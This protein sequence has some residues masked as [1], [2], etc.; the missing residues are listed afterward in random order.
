MNLCSPGRAENRVH[1][2]LQVKTIY[3][4]TGLWRQNLTEKYGGIQLSFTVGMGVKHLASV[5]LPFQKFK[6]IVILISVLKNTYYSHSFLLT[7]WKILKLAHFSCL[8][9][10]RKRQE[11]EKS[12]NQLST[13]NY[14]I[15]IFIYKCF[16]QNQIQYCISKL[17]ADNL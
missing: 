17:R 2:P 5:L 12:K 9:G 8:C 4:Q 6:S 3:R 7:F 13:F 15:A 16:N 14:L 11:M 10:R 1:F